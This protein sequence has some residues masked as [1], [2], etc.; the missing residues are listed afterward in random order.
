MGK[1]STLDG[2]CTE[3]SRVLK[4]EIEKMGTLKKNGDLMGTQ[5]LKKVPMGTRVPKW[6]PTW[7]Q[8]II[9]CVK[10][11]LKTIYG[12]NILHQ[13][14]PILSK[15]VDSQPSLVS[16]WRQKRNANLECQFR[17]PHGTKM[18]NKFSCSSGSSDEQHDPN[19]ASHL[20]ARTTTF[21][22]SSSSYVL[23]YN[24][25][26]CRNKS[27]SPFDGIC[28]VL[29]LLVPVSPHKC[30]RG[31]RLITIRFHEVF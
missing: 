30:W 23:C 1:W 2:G 21:E 24:S 16:P 20:L 25:L 14:L 29:I 10:G 28:L 18:T 12:Q 3:F 17:K 5:N 13:I 4:P 9:S 27:L 15:P 11:K 8:C 7:E 31:F 22:G 6:G 19:H 26:H